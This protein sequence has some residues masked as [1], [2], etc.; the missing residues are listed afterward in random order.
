M[1]IVHT[2]KQQVRSANAQLM[3]GGG[4]GS[5]SW[6]STMTTTMTITVTTRVW[7]HIRPPSFQPQNCDWF[8]I[9]RKFPLLLTRKKNDNLQKL[10]YPWQGMSTQF[11]LQTV[12]PVVFIVI[13]KRFDECLPRWQHEH[14]SIWPL[15]WCDLKNCPP[16]SRYR[17]ELAM[18]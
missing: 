5:A 2:L 6:A 14:D 17:H 7:H 3:F 18:N 8:L 1:S 9:S 12:K 4:E 15:H 16:S 11:S 13:E 10:I